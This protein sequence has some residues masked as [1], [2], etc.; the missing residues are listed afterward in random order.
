MTASLR[1]N[2]DA[3]RVFRAELRRT[4]LARR[5]AIDAASHANASAAIRARLRVAFPDLAA[6][7][8]GF[9]W[10]V[11][12]EPDLRPL[13]EALVAAGGRVVLPV[14][15]RAG[16]P[17]AFREWWPGQPLVPDRYDIPTPSD[18]DFLTPQVLLL[19][20]NAFDGAGY[21]IG[22]GGGFFDRTL[23]ALSPRPL[24]VGVGFD[25]QQVDSTRPQAHDIPLDAI[26][27]ETA[28]LQRQR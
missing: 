20:V 25:F 11:Q 19:P 15:V 6:R 17:L 7:I 8:V 22:Y 5:G 2:D 28:L 4:M 16:A 26:V 14:V 3:D 1:D 9:C 27:T 23:A 10:P 24:V 12:N 18:G 21:R 13:A